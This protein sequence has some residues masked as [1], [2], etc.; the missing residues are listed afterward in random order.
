MPKEPK[1]RTVTIESKNKCNRCT[2]NFMNQHVLEFHNY[3]KHNTACFHC[4][5]CDQG[6]EIFFKDVIELHRHIQNVHD[7]LD[8]INHLDIEA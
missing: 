1:L 8:K 7:E 2:V 5:K 6:Q 3:A 4:H